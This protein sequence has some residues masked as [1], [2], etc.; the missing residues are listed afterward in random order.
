MNDRFYISVS[1][2]YLFDFISIYDVKL[3]KKPSKLAHNNYEEA[4]KDAIS[5]LGATV[6]HQIILSSEYVNLFLINERLFDLVEL[7][8]D[9]LVR[10]S[11]VDR[12]VIERWN[13]KKKLQDRFSPDSKMNEEKFNRYEDKK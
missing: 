12:M 8:K 4:K 1:L 6:F 7:A 5:Q 10:A 2:G 9:D 3:K 11:D 13:A